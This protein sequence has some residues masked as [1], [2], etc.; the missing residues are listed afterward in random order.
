MTLKSQNTATLYKYAPML[1]S[2]LRM[3]PELRGVNSD[4]Q[5]ENP[6]VTV[7][8]DRDKAHSLG[9]SANAI[10]DALY[11]AYGSRQISTIYAPNDEYWVIMEVEPQYQADPDTLSMLYVRLV[12]RCAGAA[13]HAGQVHAI[14]WPVAD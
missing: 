14:A 5:V 12:H 3:L 11:D 10:E 9:I 8:I 7:D 13:R 2:K 4:L 6:Q 1:E